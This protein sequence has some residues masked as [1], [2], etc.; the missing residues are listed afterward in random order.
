MR[1]NPVL[2]RSERTFERYF[3]TGAFAM[4]GRLE[5][6]DAPRDVFRLP[7]INNFDF[8]VYKNIP[9]TER[10]RAQ[11]RWEMY[12][13]FN[14][15]QFDGVDTGARFDSLGRQINARF[16]QITSARNAREMQLSLRVEF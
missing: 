2:P 3:N 13:I 11:F 5:F 16:G 10:W 9:I 6:G 14:H 12:N 1:A 8:S 4:P 7:G 15:T